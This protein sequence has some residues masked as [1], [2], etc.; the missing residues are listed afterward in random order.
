M[1]GSIRTVMTA[2]LTSVLAMVAYAPQV[3][4]GLDEE[5]MLLGVEA[6]APVSEEVP[7]SID[8]MSEDDDAD[9][10]PNADGDVASTSESNVAPAANESP[11]AEE[12]G[13]VPAA[14]RR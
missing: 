2:L 13:D 12:A 10:V 5:S 11:L 8:I 14:G 6:A 3:A 4:R 7:V 1:R 9:I